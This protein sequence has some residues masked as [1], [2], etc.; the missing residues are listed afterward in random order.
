MEK[1]WVKHYESGVAEMLDVKPFPSLQHSFKHF[2]DKFADN[3]AFSNFDVKLTYGELRNRSAELAAYMQNE[4]GIKKGDS[5]AIMMPNL[6]QYPITLFACV[7]LGA[8]IVNVNPLFTARELKHQ[9]KDS[10][11]KAIV[12]CANFAHTLEAVVAD[13]ALEHI[14]LTELG[15]CLPG[16]KGR[17]INFVVKHVKKMVPKFH[18]SNTVSFNEALKR[19]ADLSLAPVETCLEDIACLQY[20]GGTTG[21]A[22]GAVLTHGNLVANA[23][24]FRAWGRTVIVGGKDVIITPLPMYHIFS[25]TVC[26]LA[27][28]GLG[29]ESLLI[30][31]PRDIP[32]FIKIL[33]K[34]RGTI[35]V[36]INTLYNALF[37]HP[38]IGEVD[39]SGLKISIGGGMAT[40]KVVSDQ[41]KRITG[42]PILEGYGLTETSP[43]VSACSMAEQ[44]FTGSVG[45]PLPNTEVSI[46]DDDGEEVPM[47][48][49]GEIWVRG[50]QVMAGYWHRPEETAHVLRAD[51]WLLTGDIGRFDEGGHLY[52]VDRKKDMVIVSGFN[53]YPNEVESV[54]VE[55]E[56]ITQ[57]AIIG[58]PSEQTGEA[59]KAFVVSSN[60]EL[61]EEEIIAHC[62]QSLT[63]YKVPKLYEFREELPTTPVGKVLRRKLRDGGDSD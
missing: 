36:G 7:Q 32:G 55:H 47:G 53:V 5:V 61:T 26:C 43:I 28:M 34:S 52:I 24:Q 15:D 59:V 6:L 62:R 40:Q 17:L 60:P 42:T 9:L 63:A 30:T 21:P 41:W 4:M 57:A 37:N 45:Y 49:D 10:G 39:F 18:L 11:A 13:S 1:I 27:M 16:L 22:K 23:N 50:P 3:T 12:I 46:R 25:L 35:F 44:E 14:V 38:K 2:S 20:T 54:L 58:V 33:K 29:A 31:N 19:G 51:G 56:A 8:I 48:H